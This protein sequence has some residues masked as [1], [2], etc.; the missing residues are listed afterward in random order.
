MQT[1]DSKTSFFDFHDGR[2]AITGFP[3]TWFG[4]ISC[5]TFH[6]VQTISFGNIDSFES[7]QDSQVLCLKTTNPSNYENSVCHDFQGWRC[8]RPLLWFFRELGFL[9]ASYLLIA[10]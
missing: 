8:A 1:F 4:S 9:R 5:S 6:H 10:E 2:P 3:V 7:C